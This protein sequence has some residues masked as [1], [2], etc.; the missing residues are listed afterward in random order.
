M[1]DAGLAGVIA[2]GLTARLPAPDASGLHPPHRRFRGAV[3]VADASGFTALTAA[4]EREHGA[5]GADRLASAINRLLARAIDAVVDQGGTVVEIV[6]DAIQA[7]WIDDGQGLAA[8]RSRAQ[9]AADAVTAL[10]AE[11]TAAIRLRAGVGVGRFEAAAVGGF[12]DR[13][14]TV[15][16]GPALTAALDPNAA[17]AD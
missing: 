11:G 5:R 7:V 17:P 8:C 10:S 3:M 1:S 13:W 14:D 9:A 15:I 16:W 4:L 2:G 12:Q 6:G